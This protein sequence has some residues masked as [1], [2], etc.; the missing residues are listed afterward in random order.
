M[1]EDVHTTLDDARHE[2]QKN[3]DKLLARIVRSNYD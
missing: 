1:M 3:I 2:R